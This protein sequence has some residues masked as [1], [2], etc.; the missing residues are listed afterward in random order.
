M[1]RNFQCHM[2][3]FSCWAHGPVGLGL[4]GAPEVFYNE[5]RVR[6]TLFHGCT[7]KYTDFK[8]SYIEI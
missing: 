5:A 7:P 6:S 3:N 8:I 2:V 4:Q 1:H